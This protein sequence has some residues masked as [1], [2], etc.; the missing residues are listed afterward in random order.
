[1]P[2]R[3]IDEVHEMVEVYMNLLKGDP[4]KP[5]RNEEE[6]SMY[7]GMEMAMAIIERRP[8]FFLNINKDYNKRDMEKHP[9]LFI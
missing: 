9:D 4:G 3:D 7:N 5:F 8:T 1:M 2:L 6:M